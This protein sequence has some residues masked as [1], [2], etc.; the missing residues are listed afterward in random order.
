MNTQRTHL[1]LIPCEKHAAI[2]GRQAARLSQR[3]DS[4]LVLRQELLTMIEAM[5]KGELGECSHD[6]CVMGDEL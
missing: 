4:G 6:R 3:S 1:R 5:R 2:L